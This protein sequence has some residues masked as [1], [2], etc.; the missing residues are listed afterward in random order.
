MSF[1]LKLSCFLYLDVRVFT[2][3]KISSNHCVGLVP[4]VCT[5]IHFK[6]LNKLTSLNKV[7][8][9]EIKLTALSIMTRNLFEIWT[10][11][12]CLLT[13]NKLYS[14]IPLPCTQCWFNS[15]IEYTSLNEMLDS[16]VKLFLTCK[17]VTPLFF[18]SYD[19][20]WESSF[21]KFNGLSECMAHNI[22]IKSSI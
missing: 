21:S 14:S 7:F 9:S 3:R 16:L 2:F 20:W 8:F 6:C 11:H 15:F 17:P 4:L 19:M 5:N 13:W 12:F 22:T 1:T 18:Q 10:G